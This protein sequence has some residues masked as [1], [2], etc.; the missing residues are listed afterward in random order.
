[1]VRES[2]MS[3][4]SESPTKRPVRV[5]F[6]DDHLGFPGGVVHGCTT[7]HINIQPAFDRSRAITFIAILRSYHPAAKTLAELGV[8]VTFFGRAKWD[9]RAL[10]DIIQLIHKLDIDVVHANGHKSHFLRRIAGMLT[11]AKVIIH[12]HRSYKPKPFWLSRIL[13]KK[14]AKAITVSNVLRQQAID[15]FAIPVERA[16]TIYL[17]IDVARFA[18]PAMD[19]RSRIRQ[20]F[21][22]GET[23]SVITVC[24]RI[25]TQPDKGQ[26]AAIRM[27]AKL[28]ERPVD[29]I[30]MFV[31]DGPARSECEK[32]AQ[33]LGIEDRVRF[34]GHRNDIPDILAA[35]DLQLVPSIVEEAFAYVA[36]EAMCAKRP[37]IA[38]NVGGMGEVL[39]N[40]ERGVLVN[41]K[42]VDSVVDVCERL[43]TQ[44]EL[45]EKQIERA[46]DFVSKLT[47][48]EH[49]KQL[50]DVYDDIVTNS[51]S[52]AIGNTK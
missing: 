4:T 15:D 26:V 47:T 8:D 39:G 48:D 10:V 51:P 40:G 22:L 38:S 5:L 50:C 11:R 52:N 49:I 24:G 28:C 34:A 9:P 42:D 37:V 13:A 46:W 36:L 29:A 23:Q 33:T 27:F 21:E 31:G 18:N 16:Q 35:A 25:T 32:M 3:K 45:A 7:W 12:L 43:I 30:L 20:E 6:V 14:T 2:S 17:P 41:M 1:M 19:A 44:P